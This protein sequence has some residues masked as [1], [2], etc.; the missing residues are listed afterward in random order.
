MNCDESIIH[1]LNIVNHNRQKF[2]LG[3][4]EFR[5]FVKVQFEQILQGW[6]LNIKLFETDRVIKRKWNIKLHFAEYSSNFLIII[7][8]TSIISLISP[9]EIIFRQHFE[10]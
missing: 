2:R 5:T 4:S 8:F 1:W 9:E 10:G 3:S 7:F 6:H